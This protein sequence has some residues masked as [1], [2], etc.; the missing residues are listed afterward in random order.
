MTVNIRTTTT[1]DG[2]RVSIDPQPYSK[3]TQKTRIFVTLHDGDVPMERPPYGSKKGDGSHEDA[4]WKIYNKLEKQIMID[5]VKRVLEGLGLAGTK[6]SFSKTAGCSCP[7]SP[8]F[9]ADRMLTGKGVI[10]ID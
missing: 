5:R 2:H 10:Y 8:G 9:I 4:L 1:V 6:V 7:C 3:K